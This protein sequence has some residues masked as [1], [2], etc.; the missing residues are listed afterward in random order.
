MR[1]CRFREDY[2]L[3]MKVN[4]PLRQNYGGGGGEKKK[5][6]FLAGGEINGREGGEINV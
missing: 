5:K 3:E 6:A 4:E 2:W 1:H